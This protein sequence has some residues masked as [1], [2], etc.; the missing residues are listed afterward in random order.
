ML[1]IYYVL[2]INIFNVLLQA[3]CCIFQAI[4]Y[5]IELLLLNTLKKI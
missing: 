4:E 5:K 2:F 1:N 3:K